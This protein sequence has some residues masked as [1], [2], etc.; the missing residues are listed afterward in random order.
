VL[1]PKITALHASPEEKFARPAEKKRSARFDRNQTG[2][3][4][5]S[6]RWIA[7]ND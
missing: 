7:R 5:S 2:G 1:K 4:Y 3:Y 6:L